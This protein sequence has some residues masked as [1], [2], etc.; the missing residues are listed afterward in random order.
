MRLTNVQK[1]LL[2]TPVLLGMGAVS[3]I[4]PIVRAGQLRDV[5]QLLWWFVTLPVFGAAMAAFDMWLSRR[6]K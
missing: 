6:D 2:I 1:N 4:I 5:Y 3:I